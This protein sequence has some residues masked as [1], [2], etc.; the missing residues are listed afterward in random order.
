MFRLFS[1]RTMIPFTSSPHFFCGFPRQSGTKRPTPRSVSL[2]AQRNLSGQLW[3]ALR[4]SLSNGLGLI[5]D[6]SPITIVP[7]AMRLS[8]AL[9]SFT[10]KVVGRGDYFGQCPWVR[11]QHFPSDRGLFSSQHSDAVG[12]QRYQQKC[13]VSLSLAGAT[14]VMETCSA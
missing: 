3:V 1:R 9:S 11:R 10:S 5:P 4:R 12:R 13:G 14:T 2:L 8:I 7:E 6:F